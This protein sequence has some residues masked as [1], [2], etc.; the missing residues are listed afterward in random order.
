MSFSRGLVRPLKVIS[1]RGMRWT[2]GTVKSLWCVVISTTS[3]NSTSS[4]LM[5]KSKCKTRLIKWAHSF[6][7]P[8]TSAIFSKDKSTAFL[9]TTIV[10]AT[11]LRCSR[12]PSQLYL[13]MASLHLSQLP[14]PRTLLLTKSMIMC[15]L[16]LQAHRNWRSSL[17]NGNRSKM[18]LQ[19]VRALTLDMGL[20]HWSKAIS[21]SLPTKLSNVAPN[22]RHFK[23][24]DC[25]KPDN[26]SIRKCSNSLT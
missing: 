9:K 4:L 21:R 5:T 12:T 1:S 20:K 14:N 22:E 18:S 16:E 19:L 13:P 10:S 23:K 24:S 25:T 11:C 17:A 7:H 15:L 2:S 3:S 6:P 26:F 8:S